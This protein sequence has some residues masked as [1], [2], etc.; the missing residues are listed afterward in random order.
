LPVGGGWWRFLGTI[1]NH[2]HKWKPSE[3]PVFMVEDGGFGRFKFVN[4]R[5]SQDGE[6]ES[7]R[8]CLFTVSRKQMEMEDVDVNVLRRRMRL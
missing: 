2:L 3:K 8:N 6:I 1:P 7:N 5:F 4:F